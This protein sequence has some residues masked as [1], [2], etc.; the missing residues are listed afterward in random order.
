MVGKSKLLKRW[1]ALGALICVI[2]GS[3][4][5]IFSPAQM[6]TAAKVSGKGTKI[7]VV[8]DGKKVGSGRAG[9]KIGKNYM[10]DAKAFAKKAKVKYSSKKA[11]K[12]V[13]LKS[14]AV[15]LTFAIGKKKVARKAKVGKKSVRADIA[16]RLV[17]KKVY[18]SAKTVATQFGYKKPVYANKTLRISKKGVK[19]DDESTSEPTISEPVGHD[20]YSEG[21][22]P[23]LA[24]VENSL[25]R[26]NIVI[27]NGYQMMTPTRE[28]KKIKHNAYI[29]VDD[30]KANPTISLEKTKITLSGRGNSTFYEIPENF[31][32]LPMKFKFDKG[33][34]HSMC[35]L[36][37]GRSWN[38]LAELYDKSL[39]RNL[40]AQDFAA[41]L[42]G[43]E[44]SIKCI[45]VELYINGKYRGVYTLTQKIATNENCVNIDTTGDEPGFLV[46]RCQRSFCEA[47]E[48][49]IDNPNKGNVKI[50]DAFFYDTTEASAAGLA[51]LQQNPTNV[52]WKNVLNQYFYTDG[53]KDWNLIGSSWKY[54]SPDADELTAVQKDYISKSVLDVHNAIKIKATNYK[55]LIDMDSFVDFYLLNFFFLNSDSGFSSIYMY[56]DKGADSK[57]HMG[58]VWDYDI[59]IGNGEAE[60]NN[61]WMV[62][63]VPWLKELWGQSW[64][65]KTQ[66]QSRWKE[67]SINGDIVQKNLI[68]RIDYYKNMLQSAQK[69]NF[70]RWPI[71]TL[72]TN[73]TGS[74]TPSG[75]WEE[76]VDYL[77]DW[78]IRRKEYLDSWIPNPRY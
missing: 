54:K 55:D 24:P 59:Y 72:N 1:C 21:V 8:L 37:A 36:P 29:Q 14:S 18:V 7:K 62:T 31:P 16:T 3:L 32:K 67:I 30:G 74:R 39:M 38:L 69:R 2:V 63:W 47:I 4:G 66:F 20:Y 44:Y 50:D 26:V 28:A 10:V 56:K 25:Q 35:G 53:E 78:L 75:T 64:S 48:D 76:E 19:A 52:K 71:L 33:V 43:L 57:L 13:V 65:F 49:Y 17:G 15:Q 5:G 23:T 45:P 70:E 12:K 27:E 58:P 22:M 41:A 46:E 9:L 34:K 6:V 60:V 42:T 68:D 51:L 11:G 73:F 77:K 40:I 61:I